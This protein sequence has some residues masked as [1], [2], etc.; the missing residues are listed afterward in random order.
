MRAS[1]SVIEMCNRTPVGQVQKVYLSQPM[2]I[3]GIWRA[4]PGHTDGTLKERYHGLRLQ[5]G[6][7]ESEF[8]FDRVAR[9]DNFS[10]VGDAL[11]TKSS[12]RGKGAPWTFR[13]ATSR[14]RPSRS[15][16]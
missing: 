12:S 9:A 7:G 4:K 8:L 15:A 3:N 13:T 10:T 6:R 11:L 2:L 16:P 1:H 5:F 14:P